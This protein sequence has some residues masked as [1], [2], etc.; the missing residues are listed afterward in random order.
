MTDHVHDLSIG[1]DL[2][3]IQQT[4]EVYAECG[5]GY[6]LSQEEAEA[7]LNEHAALKRVRDAA[8]EI[9]ILI[10]DDTYVPDSFTTQPLRIALADTQEQLTK[11]R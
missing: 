11:D 2:D 6:V 7:M 1:F 9:V 4:V 10:D 3:I 8:E 5:C